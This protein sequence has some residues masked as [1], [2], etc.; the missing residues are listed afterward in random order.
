MVA[1]SVSSAAILLLALFWY[2]LWVLLLL[3]A[4]ILL[5]TLLSGLGDLINRVTHLG[6]RASVIIGLVLLIGTTVI[7]GF[8]AVP[9]IASQMSDLWQEI[10]KGVA[11]LQSYLENY[12]WGRWLIQQTGPL[13]GNVQWVT[14]A[15]GALSST[16]GAIFSLM[17]V[18]FLAIYFALS[19]GLYASAILRL[20]PMKHRPRAQEVLGSLGYTLRR[21]LV[22]QLATMVT[23]GVLTTLGLWLLG[24]PLALI[25]GILAFLLDFIP[26]FGPFIAATPAVL[27][28]LIIDPKTAMWV[29]VVYIAVQQIEGLIVSPLIHQR[30]VSLPPAL[31]ISAQVLMGVLAGGLGLLLATP[32]VAVAMVLVKMLYVEQTLGDQVDTPA[33]H[34]KASDMPP[35]PQPQKKED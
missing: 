19:P 2:A 22:G 31:T 8:Y 15:T 12:A 27:M 30:T 32:L 18:G 25:L 4:G 5:A 35:L 20:V 23:V 9:A 26:N 10:P 34:M 29:A 21:W 14:R 1:V 6:Y 16:L 33:D 24:I 7:V 13:A 3:F 28:G 17:V 11:R